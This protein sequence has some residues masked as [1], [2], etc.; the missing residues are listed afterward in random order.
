MLLKL[1]HLPLPLRQLHISLLGECILLN[2]T[3][4]VPFVFLDETVLVPFAFLD[5]TVLVPFVQKRFVCLWLVD[6]SVRLFLC[7]SV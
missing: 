1:P 5:E 3:V 7:S 4:L 2:K 6:E